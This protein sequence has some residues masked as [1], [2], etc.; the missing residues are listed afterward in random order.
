MSSKKRELGGSTNN[1]KKAKVVNGAQPD[2]LSDGLDNE[3][4]RAFVKD[5]RSI[6]QENAGKKTH[7]NIV[8]SISEDE[9]YKA[10]IERY[11]ML[12]DMI[13]KEVGFEMESLEY[14]LSMRGKIINGNMSSEA[15]SKEVGQVWFD[16]Y[17]KEPK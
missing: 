16:K 11:P 5:I 8:N 17:Y 4:I 1:N 9:K 6:I 12:F 10:F 2:F 15:A 13:T 14:F 3:S 7:A